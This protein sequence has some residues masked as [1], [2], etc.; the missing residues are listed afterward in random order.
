MPSKKQ[1]LCCHKC[2]R[3]P[4]KWRKPELDIIYC[5]TT[6]TRRTQRPKGITCRGNRDAGD[7]LATALPGPASVRLLTFSKSRK[8]HYWTALIMHLRPGQGSAF[9]AVRYTTW[10]CLLLPSVEMKSGIVHTALCKVL[11]M[12]VTLLLFNFLFVGWIKYLVAEFIDYA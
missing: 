1:K 4:L 11:W 10:V 2:L 8:G 6:T 12:K 3:T 7:A 9:R 5:C